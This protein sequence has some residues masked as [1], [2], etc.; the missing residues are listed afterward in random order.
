MKTR[1]SAVLLAGAIC[2]FVCSSIAQTIYEA[3]DATLSGPAPAN[4]NGG[5]SGTG[6]ADYAN[7]SGDYVEFALS[8][9]SAG[10]YPIAFRYA[11]GGTTDRPLQLSV[12]GAPVVASLSFPPTGGWTTWLYT[13]TNNVTFNAGLNK[14]RI[15]AIG[16][17]GANVDHMLVT[18]N[19]TSAPAPVTNNIISA[20][21]RRSI[22]PSQPMWLV[23]IDTWNYADPQKI[24]D[25]IPADIRPY[26]VMNISL[27]ISHDNTADPGRY[28]IV[29]YGYETAKSWV[30][31]CAQNQMWCI[32]Q[33]S[34]GGFSHLS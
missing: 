19:G 15:T 21:F 28:N 31:A 26:V 8:A 1:K 22:S 25:L 29:E 5:Y 18:V 10:S 20:P 17:S 6:Y 11:N 27:S 12:N 23:H 16:S 32:V 4:S 2:L 9:T 24:I 33:P 14:V 34:S 13:A 7:N 3:E 30:R